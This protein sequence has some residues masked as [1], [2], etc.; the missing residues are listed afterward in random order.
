MPVCQPRINESI[1]LAYKNHWI[2][3]EIILKMWQQSSILPTTRVQDFIKRGAGRETLWGLRGECYTRTFGLV[4]GRFN[5]AI[6]RRGA[7]KWLEKG[8]SRVLQIGD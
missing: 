3:S 4:H 2:L 6:L 8:Q 1:T 5:L 7:G